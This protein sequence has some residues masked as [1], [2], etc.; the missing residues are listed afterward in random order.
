[1]SRG[2]SAALKQVPEAAGEV[3]LEAADGFL[4]AFAFGA[5][6][7][8]VVLGFGVA[9]QAGDGDAMD[10]RVDLAVAAAIE[11]VA[12]GLAGADGDR[13][14]AG[15]A[16]ELGV[17]GEPVRAGDLADKLGRG[18]RPQTGLAEQL[19][20]DLVDEGAD[21]CLERLERL[22]ELA[23]A[24]QL[25]TRDADARGLL[26]AREPSGDA[27]APGAVEQRA[28]R[29]SQFGPEVVQMPL[30][31]VVE[32][33]AL[34]DEALAVVDEQPQIEFGA[35]QLRRRQGIQAFA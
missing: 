33:D 8:D 23:D 21:L 17:C 11:A 14:D 24:A 4:G 31:R 13:S 29:Q 7:G 2:G 34:A 9:A 35:L 28:A 1:V 15:G 16:R 30:Q 10:G 25:V 12:V 3:A 22:G 6:A 32:R 27:R 26:G 19:R 20:R 18:E 5:F